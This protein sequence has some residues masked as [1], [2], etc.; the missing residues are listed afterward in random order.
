MTHGALLVVQLA[1]ASQTVEGKLAMVPVSEG[2]GGVA[3]TALAMARMLGGAAFF[4]AGRYLFGWRG[5]VQRRDHLAIAGLAFIGIALNQTLFLMGLRLTSPVSAALLSVTIPVFT[6]ALA[7]LLRQER[8]SLRTLLGLSVAVVGVLWLTGV[9]A[10]DRGAA[11]VAIN[12][13]SYSLYLVTSRPVIRRLGAFPVITFVFVWACVLFAPIG[14]PALVAD[15]PRW[16]ARAWALV[17]Y[18]VVMPT[19]VAYLLN[20]WALA[21]TSAIV[22]T[23]YI[24]TQPVLAAALAWAQLGT[25]PTARAAVAAVLIALG[26]GIVAG[27][28][29]AP[30]VPASRARGLEGA[31]TNDPGGGVG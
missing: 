10:V 16:S 22:V 1:F 24:C 20:A 8:P 4:L 7:V 5:P 31:A 21:R 3:P 28:G 6:A 14:V 30:V 15:A 9:R 27:R 13:V 19:I 23:V 18:I 29:K 11:L 17:A 25:A 12:A 2:G 26:V